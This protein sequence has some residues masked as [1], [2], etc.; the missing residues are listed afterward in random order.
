MRK[1]VCL[2]PEGV[3]KV[4]CECGNNLIPTIHNRISLTIKKKTDE[5]YN[6]NYKCK[7]T[8]IYNLTPIYQCCKIKDKQRSNIP[9]E[10]HQLVYIC[11]DFCSATIIRSKNPLE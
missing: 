3:F 11:K 9:F 5:Y 6:N 1:V 8:K 4:I 2:D 10:L 7:C